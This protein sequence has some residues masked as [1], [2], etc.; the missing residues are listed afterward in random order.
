YESGA[1]LGLSDNM[2]KSFLI[3]QSLLAKQFRKMQRKYGLVPINGNR[4][5]MEI[6]KDLQDKIDYFLK[7]DGKT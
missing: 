7:S 4:S 2:L 6:H 5:M 1:D 3:Y